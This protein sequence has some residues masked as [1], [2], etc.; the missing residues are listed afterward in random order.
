MQAGRRQGTLIEIT[1][2]VEA[3]QTVITSGQNKLSNNAAIT[4]NNTVDPATVA[5]EDGSGPS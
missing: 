1:K 5:L 4:I 3:G 2:G